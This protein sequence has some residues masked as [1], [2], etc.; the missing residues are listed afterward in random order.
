MIDAVDD[1]SEKIDQEFANEAD[2]AAELHHK[3][4]EVF[5]MAGK[6]E[7]GERLEKFQQKRKFHAL[8]ALELRKQFYGERHELVAKDLFYAYGFIG[9]NERE[10][11]ALLMQAIEMMRETN[12][13][14][15]NLPYMLEAYTAR[16]ILPDN[17]DKH[18]AYL[19]ALLPPTAENK[20]QIAE[21][22]L[23]EALPIFR[24]HYKKDNHAVFANEC[25]LAYALAMQE[26]WT[27]FDEH[28]AVC[29]QG[30][31]KSQNGG[32]P[33]TIRNCVELIEKILAEKNYKK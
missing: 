28:Y 27:D 31:T 25:K 2:V 7:R 12:P 16:L 6:G 19:Q 17:E 23:R 26:K 8:R 20:Y 10:Y 5:L 33:D 13:K 9:T 32:L 3:F 24:E 4:S 30:D 18:A 1:L 29:R 11:A 15:L 21:K 14:N 22:M